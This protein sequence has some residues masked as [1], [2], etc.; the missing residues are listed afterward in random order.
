M[1]SA[2]VC[3][4]WKHQQPVETFIYTA[5]NI[6]ATV[7]SPAGAEQLQNA[8]QWFHHHVGGSDSQQPTLHIHLVESPLGYGEVKLETRLEKCLE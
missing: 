3:V 6:R 4:L 2:A 1:L 8:Y 7:D 5:L